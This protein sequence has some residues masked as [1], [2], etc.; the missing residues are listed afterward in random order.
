MVFDLITEYRKKIEELLSKRLGNARSFLDRLHTENVENLKRVIKSL[1]LEN[2]IDID[3]ISQLTELTSLIEAFG[4]RLSVPKITHDEKVVHVI[5]DV[6]GFSKEDINLDVAPERIIISGK[7]IVEGEQRTI[8]NKIIPL[9][10]IIKPNS[11]EAKLENGVLII[12]CPIL[13]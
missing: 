3:R 8:D 5:L 4:Y 10:K 12:T 1:G 13:K 11:T 2:R 6:P 9:P 7:A